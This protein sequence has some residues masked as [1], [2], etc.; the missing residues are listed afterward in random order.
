MVAIVV[1]LI[2]NLLHHCISKIS[3]A[4]ILMDSLYLTSLTCMR[5]NICY[6]HYVVIHTS[7]EQVS[8]L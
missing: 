1:Q 6:E 5:T 2:F 3:L 7:L 8:G 4:I